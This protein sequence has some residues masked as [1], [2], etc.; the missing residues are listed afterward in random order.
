MTEQ[1]KNKGGRPKKDP[2]ALSVNAQQKQEIIRCGRDPI[3]FINTYVFIQHVRKGRLKFK[4]FEYQDNIIRELQTGNDVI[5]NKS[6][7]L[8]LSTVTAAYALWLILFHRDKNVLVIATKLGVA[9]NFMK[10]VFY[11]YDLL[12]KW[13]MLSAEKSR[14]KTEL[15]LKNGSQVK[16][17]PTSVDAGRSEALSLVVIDE[18]V[19][20]D[21]EIVLR[22]TASD[23]VGARTIESL[24][25]E[26]S[27]PQQISP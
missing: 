9:Q 27:V 18:C 7:Q 2:N 25:E 13:L 15:G 12:P 20:G 19:T 4:T 24:F 5:T 23:T 16:A 11:A 26:L 3:Y 17:I 8:G 22:N 21:T 14:T 10:K 6:R 1:V